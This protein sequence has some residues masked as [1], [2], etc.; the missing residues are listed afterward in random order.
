MG[1]RLTRRGLGVAAILPAAAMT[2]AAHAESAGES[3]FERVQR[4]KTLRI[5]ALP[6]ELPWFVKDISSGEWA[7]AAIAMAHDLAKVF[8]AELAYVE[9][10]YGNSVLDLQSNKVDLAF[11]LNPTPARALSVRFAH[12]IITHPFGCLARKGFEPKTWSDIDKPDVRIAVDLG[13]A[14][15]AVARRFAPKAQ[16]S[17]FRNRDEAVL[18]LQSGRVDVDIL[19]ATLGLSA[20]AKNP[21]LGRYYLLTDPLVALPS[22]CAVQREPDTRF[23]EVVNAYLDYNRGIGLTREYVLAGLARVGVKPEDL[24]PALTL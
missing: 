11:A 21:G 23:E 19:A 5:A 13:S 2:R 3:T 8:G 4:T 16:I 24:P 22:N 15:E 1:N 14:H 6:G 9:S 17:G 20:V 7:G 12:P 18:A 10:T